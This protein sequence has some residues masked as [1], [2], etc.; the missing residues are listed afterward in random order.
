[1]LDKPHDY[2]DTGQATQLMSRPKK[3]GAGSVFWKG[4]SPPLHVGAEHLLCKVKVYTREEIELIAGECSPPS[5]IKKCEIAAEFYW[6][7][8]K[9]NF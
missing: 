3:V 2:E 7:P 4:D 8:R 9:Y 1:M 6:K 5:G